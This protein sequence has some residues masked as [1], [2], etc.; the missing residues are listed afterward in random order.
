M[1]D[2]GH[3]GEPHAVFHGPI[4]LFFC[5]FTGLKGSPPW[6][7]NVP[8]TSNHCPF[9]LPVSQEWLAIKP[10]KWKGP[11]C[12]RKWR[13]CIWPTHRPD[14]R[15]DAPFKDS[16]SHADERGAQ[17]PWSYRIDQGRGQEDC[18]M[19]NS[20]LTVPGALERVEERRQKT[21][22]AGKSQW[23]PRNFGPS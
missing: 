17:H 4:A 5:F 15:G 3:E 6:Q 2:S 19:P 7:F 22:R 12:L 14:G 8:L 21:E 16:N 23:R 13:S 10:L 1:N 9:Y 18:K 20:S 11:I